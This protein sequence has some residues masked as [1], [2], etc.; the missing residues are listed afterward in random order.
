MIAQ[1]K[2]DLAPTNFEQQEQP[3]TMADFAPQ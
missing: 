3:L 2:N 1:R